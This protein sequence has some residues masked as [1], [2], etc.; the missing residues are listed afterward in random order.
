MEMWGNFFLMRNEVCGSSKNISKHPTKNR[1][2]Y[3]TNLIKIRS[4]DQKKNR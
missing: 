1:C 2:L 4:T 3:E